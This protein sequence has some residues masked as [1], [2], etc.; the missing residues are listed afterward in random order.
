[1]AVVR[2]TAAMSMAVR[3]SN[4]YFLNISRHN[5]A[6]LLLGLIISPAVW[7]EDGAPAGSGPDIGLEGDEPVRIYRTREERREAGLEHRLTPW[8]TLAGLG[9]L[10][11]RAERSD[12]R[13]T[14]RHE[15]QYDAIAG[16][17]LS[18]TATPWRFLKAEA[19]LDYDSEDRK[20]GLDEFTTAC[21]YG[22]WELAAGKQY[23]PFG[24]FFS[25]FV[26]G[27]LLEFGETRA[28]S[29]IASYGPSDRFDLSIYAYQGHARSFNSPDDQPD[30]GLAVEYSFF[31]LGM[32]GAS[33]LSD[34]ADSDGGLLV[35]SSDRYASRVPGWSAHAVAGFGK[36]EF[37]AEYLG[38]LG[39]YEELVSAYNSPRAWN[40]ELAYYP[41][42]RFGW[43]LRLEG[44]HE[45]ENAARRRYGAALTWRVMGNASLTVVYLAAVYRND[46]DQRAAVNEIDLVNQFGAQWNIEF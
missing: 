7:S 23:L 8:L 43:A 42:D 26:S 5:A 40:L 20:V 38:A 21:E 36:F 46:S 18:L 13:H 1:M 14:S 17:Q 22:A 9:E 3:G 39:S 16:L 31:S 44:S 27:P 37:V 33:Y 15:E 29:L 25:H 45:L 34:L 12:F 32:L 24:I 2:Y 19:I 35:D 41:D 4:R 30:W 6:A 11:W 28:R 10:E